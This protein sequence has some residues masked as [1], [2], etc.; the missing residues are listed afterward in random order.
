MLRP[1]YTRKATNI[2]LVG[3]PSSGKRTLAKQLL[4]SSQ[5][6]L[7]TYTLEEITIQELNT[8]KDIDYVLLLVDFTNPFSTKL[9]E[10]YLSHMTNDFLLTR[11][12][13]VFTKVDQ[14]HLWMINDDR[15]YEVIQQFGNITTFYVNLSNQVSRKKTTEQIIRLI[16]INTSQQRHISPFT[17]QFLSHS[18]PYMN[19]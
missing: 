19:K 9:L 7:S 6:Y 5:V 10:T 2:L 12:S 18:L 1:L 15:I 8:I 3:T 16:C 4:Q 11:C 17:S 13:I 14:K